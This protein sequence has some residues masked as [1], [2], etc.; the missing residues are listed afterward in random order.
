MKRALPR[1][2]LSV[3]VLFCCNAFGQP[4]PSKPIRLVVPSAAGGS[5]DTVA[6]LIGNA[7]SANL[8][9]PVVI[10][11]RPGA[12]GNI[13]A[14]IVAAAPPD[15]YTLLI[16]YGGFAINPTLYKKLPF[17]PIKDFA[18]VIQICTVTGILVVIPSLPVNSVKE[19]IALAKAKPGQLNFA[20]AGSGTVTQLAGELFKT[21]AGVD[22]VHVPYRGSS[23]ALT[24]LLGGQVQMMFANIPG[25]LQHV[26]TGRLRI[27]A[28]NS[29][30]RS[31][32]LPNV[33]TVAESGL[34]GYEASTWFG[35]LA[36]AATPKETVAKL[37]TEIARVLGSKDIEAALK[38]D[39]AVPVGGSPEQFG[40]FVR[41]EIEKW[42]K[43][44]RASGAR[45]D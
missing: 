4:Y 3:F 44:V 2:V 35:V 9:V 43:V 36:P 17:D 5:T 31:P 45:A 8:G 39:G 11:D 38:S 22:I 32:L 15:G 14:E 1:W 26:E 19:L 23:L 21:M 18:P 42:G 33:P 7:L 10:D 41:A 16:P 27:L 40:T 29:A 30:T 34:P 24:D 20:S 12:G 25:T 6:R 37:N 28:V 13:A